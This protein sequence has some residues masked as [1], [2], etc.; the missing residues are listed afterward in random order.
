ML[1]RKYRLHRLVTDR[2]N[3]LSQVSQFVEKKFARR[4]DLERLTEGFSIQVKTSGVDLSD[5]YLAGETFTPICA[6]C[7]GAHDI[8]AADFQTLL[9]PL[10][11]AVVDG[12][13]GP[14]KRSL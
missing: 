7:H 6:D 2:C 13:H 14:R 3:L 8:L 12:P 5:H 1:C 4:R 11:L 9:N 10:S